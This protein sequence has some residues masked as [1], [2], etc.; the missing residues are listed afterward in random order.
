MSWTVLLAAAWRVDGEQ[1]EDK[2][3]SWEQ[4]GGC[5]KTGDAD[6]CDGGAQTMSVRVERDNWTQR[7]SGS[8]FGQMPVEGETGAAG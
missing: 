8:V 3:K 5:A 7:Y 2:K 6:D 4:L 1:G